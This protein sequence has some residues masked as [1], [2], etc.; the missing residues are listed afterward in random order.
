MVDKSLAYSNEQMFSIGGS[1]AL[2]RRFPSYQILVL[3][4]FEHLDSLSYFQ[5]SYF[6]SSTN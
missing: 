4:I 1:F 2:T 6:S 5:V 3:E